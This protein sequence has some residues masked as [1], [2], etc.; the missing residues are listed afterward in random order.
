MDES[1]A[2]QME[3]YLKTLIVFVHFLAAAYVLMSIVKLDWELLKNYRNPLA[4]HFVRRICDAK[5]STLFA[6]IVL[7]L[8][9]FALIAYGQSINPTYLQN[10]KLWVK[11]IVVGLLTANGIF[12]HALSANVQ[13]HTILAEL[14]NPIAIKLN[15]IGA[16]SSSSWLF[17][18]VLGVARAWNNTLPFAQILSYYLLTLLIAIAVS[19]LH[20]FNMV[21]VPRG[22]L[23]TDY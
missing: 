2:R 5:R 11:F 23:G 4:A 13:E 6:L 9:G 18:C 20:H 15:V 17:A 21:Q 22:L 12:V 8:T 19:L 10:E 14:S 16:I 3:L 1:G 7:Y